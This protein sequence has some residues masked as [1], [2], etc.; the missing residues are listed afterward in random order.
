MDFITFMKDVG[1][2]LKLAKKQELP[3]NI[4]YAKD[5]LKTLIVEHTRFLIP[6]SGQTHYKLS[7]IKWDMTKIP[8]TIQLISRLCHL[9]R[10]S[11]CVSD[12][13]QK[14]LVFSWFWR[15]TLSIMF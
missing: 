1:I 11:M 9:P 12:S 5:I 6:E 15:T 7:S 14:D 8:N 2:S 13:S 3:Q 10:G 4:F